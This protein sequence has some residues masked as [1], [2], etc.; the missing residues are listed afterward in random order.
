MPYKFNLE[1]FLKKSAEEQ[2]KIIERET[3]KVIGRLPSLK[4][5]LKMRRSNSSLLFQKK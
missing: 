5:N 3:Q 4:K 2:A 1:S